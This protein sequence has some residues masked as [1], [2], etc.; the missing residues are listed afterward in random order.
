MNSPR[1]YAQAAE[2]LQISE[3]QL[4]KLVSAGRVPYSKIGRCVRFT[5]D[6]LVQILTAG[7][8][9]PRPAIGRPRLRRAA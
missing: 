3:S 8:H 2:W 6:H 7:E 1:N 4:R 5:E 9:Q